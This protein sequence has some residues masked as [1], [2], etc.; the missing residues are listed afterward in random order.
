MKTAFSINYLA[1]FP[2]HAQ[3]AA[4]WVLSDRQHFYPLET[5]EDAQ[6]RVEGC[7][8]KGEIPFSLIALDGYKAAGLAC[9]IS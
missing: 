6:R 7:L 4:A 8:S 1:D 9:V 2:E 5:L 3:T